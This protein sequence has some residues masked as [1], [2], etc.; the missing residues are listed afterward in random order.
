MCGKWSGKGSN[1][2]K[3]LIC[4]HTNL[5]KTAT[6]EMKKESGSFLVSPATVWQAVIK[7]YSWVENR[8]CWKLLLF[9]GCNILYRIYQNRQSLNVTLSLEKYT[10]WYPQCLIQNKALKFVC[11]L[12]HAT[13]CVHDILWE[14]KM[15][16]FLMIS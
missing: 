13:I 1:N 8:I 12:K 16:R 14:L 7:Y 15:I 11:Q 6:V 10:S 4:F 5:T 3:K 9:G 2:L